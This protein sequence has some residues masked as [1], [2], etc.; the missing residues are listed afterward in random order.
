MIRLRKPLVAS[1]LTLCALT[2]ASLSLPLASASFAAQEAKQ[3]APKAVTLKGT[4]SCIG[5][6]LKKA[7]GAGAQCSV[8]GHTHALKTADGKYYT[9]L[10]NKKSEPLIKGETLHGKMVEVNGTLFPG[11]QIL[12]VKE[13]KTLPD[14][15]AADS[16]AVAKLVALNVC[17]MS[18]E[19]VT[20]EGV[21][22]TLV[23]NYEVKFCCANCKTAFDALSS[24]EK[25]AKIAAAL[26]K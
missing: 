2:F 26:K 5:C 18:G 23:G 4:L 12:E 14:K 3:E 13:Y 11:T 24:A 25:D 16:A 20:G 7:H 22:K 9:F 15:P 1:V 19:A 10:Q 21:G 6:D 17:P 8:Y